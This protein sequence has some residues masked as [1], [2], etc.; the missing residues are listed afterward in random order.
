MTLAVR[1][2]TESDQTEPARGLLSS[3]RRIAIAEHL[4]ISYELHE[5]PAAPGI[6]R[7]RL[8]ASGAELLWTSAVESAGPPVEAHI[9]SAGTSI[10]IFGRVLN[11]TL[12]ER[13]LDQRG[14][15]WSRAVALLDSDG[16][17]LASIWASEDG[18]VFL[19][20]DPDE[21]CENYWS[22]R[23]LELARSG[24]SRRLQR[25]AVRVYYRVRDLLPRRTQIALRRLYAY[26]QRRRQFP[27]WPAESALHDFFDLFTA[28]LTD[29]AGEPLPR[30]AAW[31]HG[32]AWA[33]VLTHDI[34][35]TVGLRALDQVLELERDFDLRSSLN[36]VPRRY[37]VSDERIERLHADGFEVGVH[38]LYH[39]GRDLESRELLEARL[40]EIRAAAERWGAVGFRSPAT[41]RD[42]ELMPL[43][44][45]DY[46]TSYPDTDPFEPQDGGC[47][48]WLPFF[49]QAMVELPL[50]MPQDHTMFEILRHPDE[51]VWTEK[52]DFLRARGGMAMIDTHPDYLIDERIMRAYE[53]LLERYAEDPSAWK[54]LPR[55][56][57]DWWRR[58]A[59]SR[60]QWAGTGWIVTG[61]AAQ[62]ARVELVEARPWR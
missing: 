6:E 35:E 3:S 15:S 27:A 25:Q 12:A 13:V 58:R 26:K 52:A 24:A 44:G 9:Q 46:D 17:A 39:D 49:N 48:T 2:R 11:D 62:E 7:M 22:E 19:P 37:E 50:T 42:W 60:I 57:S 14:G 54:P 33:L 5:V 53:R 31:P 61:P 21:V 16:A 28:I 8:A 10:P 23:Y 41:H 1:G 36:F 18:N 29:L 47:C 59:T 32:H 30:I 55:E 20:F 38:G 51:T 34:E 56:V 43:L 45:F 40:P 4:G